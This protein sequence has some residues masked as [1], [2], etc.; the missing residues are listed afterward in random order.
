MKVGDLVM[1]T[2]GE[3]NTEAIGVIKKKIGIGAYYEVY[4]FNPP[5]KLWGESRWTPSHM[6]VIKICK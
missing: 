2:G 6:R 3:K 5:N 4:F 1:C